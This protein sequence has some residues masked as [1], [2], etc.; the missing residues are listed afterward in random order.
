MVGDVHRTLIYGGVFGY[1]ATANNPDGKLRL[2]YEA[3]PMSFLIEQAGGVSV[4]GR[5]RI[6][7]VHPKSV[8]QRVPCIMGS[9]EDVMEMK[10]YY[11]ASTDEVLISRCK[12]RMQ[13]VNSDTK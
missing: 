10:S 12:A 7:D 5:D 11:D 4:T 13:T 1:P 3:A 6:M 9:P 8:H 2:L